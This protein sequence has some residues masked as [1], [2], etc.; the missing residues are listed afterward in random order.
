[1]A[2]TFAALQ[3]K[4]K[5]ILT[6]HGQNTYLRRRCISCSQTG[7]DA[8]YQDDCIVCGGTGFAQKL[9][10]YTMRKMIVGTQSSL[11]VS[12]ERF[13]TGMIIG[14]GCYFFCEN[15]VN[16]RYGDIIYD[17]NNATLEW[18]SFDIKK[19]IERRYDSRVLFYTCACEAREISGAV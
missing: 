1:M 5:S 7:K 3:A 17:F 4:F 18:D 14:E 8:D 13:P 12:L 16:P 9:E 2:W 15:T 11:P 6:L 10:G 19:V